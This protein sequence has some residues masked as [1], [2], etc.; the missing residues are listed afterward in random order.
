MRK[1]L[2]KKKWEFES[3]RI[4]TRFNWNKKMSQ[5]DFKLLLITQPLE[6]IGKNITEKEKKIT[7][8]NIDTNH[9]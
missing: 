8:H 7:L 3:V 6:N 2:Q 4:F 1:K 9:V 5:N